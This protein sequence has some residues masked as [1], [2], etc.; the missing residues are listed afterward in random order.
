M[1]AMD[2]RDSNSSINGLYQAITYQV[3]L[4]GGAWFLSSLAAGNWPTVSSLRATIY[5]DR[6]PNG[7]LFPAEPNILYVGSNYKQI[8]TDIGAKQAA[9]YPTTIVDVYGRSL[10]YNMFNGTDGGV[11]LTM[12][13]LTSLSNFAGH[14][15]PFP[16][17]TSIG[18]DP[19]SSCSV[20]FNGT[21]YEI[22]P[23]EFGSWDIGTNAFV[24]TAYLGTNLTNGIANTNQ[25]TTGLDNL[26]FITGT[27]SDVYAGVCDP[28]EVPNGTLTAVADALQALLA[29]EAGTSANELFA[30]YPNPFFG[31][32]HS[33]EVAQSKTLYLGDGGLSLQ[34]DPIWPLIQPARDV[35]ALIVG[36]SRGNTS[37]SYPDDIAIAYTYIQAQAHNLTRMPFI[38]GPSVFISQN[39]TQRAQFFG[40]NEP[41]AV[42]MVW[43]PFAAYIAAATNV[44][45]DD[46]QVS[47]A[48][49][50][51]VISN[52][53][54]GATQ[55]DDEGWPLCLAC[56]MMKKTGSALPAGCAACFT[57]YCYNP[58]AA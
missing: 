48:D 22:S 21:Q 1:Q 52:G 38:P 9:G 11:N 34:T 16:I 26:G 57:K 43:L 24:Q 13:G 5:D 56:A 50:A 25:C 45:P 37:A 7:F 6:L 10:G 47:K 49:I 15:A 44:G 35:S 3:G 23:Y 39:L 46:L 30:T 2:S 51:S 29:E 58:T 4:S 17:V 31:C 42:T 19:T 41:N 53:N 14:S 32:P 27:S 33:P 8:D 36:D 55:G 54:L 40:C 12:S 18:R 28:Q 20:G